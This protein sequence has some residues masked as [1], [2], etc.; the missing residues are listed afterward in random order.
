MGPEAARAAFGQAGERLV[1]NYRVISESPRVKMNV[2][3][4]VPR[5]TR[6]LGGAG[7]EL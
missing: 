5:M 7:T 6:K 3:H 4:W 2:S 1:L